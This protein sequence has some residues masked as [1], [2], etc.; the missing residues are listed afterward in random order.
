MTPTQAAKHTPGPWH[1]GSQNDGLFIINQPP[2][3]S[4]DDI[5]FGT[6]GPTVIGA[7]YWQ[8][9]PDESQANARLIAQAPAM[10]EALKNLLA[11]ITS[12]G[13]CLACGNGRSQHMMNCKVYSAERVLRDAGVEL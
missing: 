12:G 6:D 8:T 5:R 4:T 2:R 9:D 11:D 1:V 13:I 10:A 3:P 7:V